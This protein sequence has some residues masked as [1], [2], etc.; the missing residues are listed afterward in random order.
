MSQ[1]TDFKKNDFEPLAAGEYMLRMNRITPKVTAKGDKAISLG[2]EVVQKVGDSDANE[3]K[4]K[5]RLVFE[6]LCL[7]N[8]NPQTVEISLEKINKIIMA[9]GEARG[10]EAIDHDV[11]QLKKYLHRPFIGKLKVKSGTNGYKDTNAI[12]SFKTI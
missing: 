6:Y 5:N 10:L 7:E 8:A 12:T 1:A 3:S 9:T 11:N 4:S 2:F